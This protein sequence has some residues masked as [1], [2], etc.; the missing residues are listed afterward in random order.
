MS[1]SLALGAEPEPTVHS[2]GPRWGHCSEAGASRRDPGLGGRERNLVLGWVLGYLNPGSATLKISPAPG[3]NLCYGEAIISFFSK[4]SLSWIFRSLQLK[5][6]QAKAT[7]IQSSPKI[8]Y[9][10]EWVAAHRYIVMI[11]QIPNCYVGEPVPGSPVLWPL[12]KF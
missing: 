4:A 10:R 9:F 5:K 7:Y 2:C 11:V 8:K 12:D 1:S 3:L 6:L